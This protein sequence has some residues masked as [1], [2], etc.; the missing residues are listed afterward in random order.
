MRYNW[1][2]CLRVPARAIPLKYALTFP[3]VLTPLLATSHGGTKTFLILAALNVTACFALSV[4]DRKNRLARHLVFG[5]TLLFVAGLPDGWLQSIAHGFSREQC[6]AFGLVAYLVFWTAWLRNPKLAILGSI[7]LASTVMS[8]FHQHAG[9]GHWALQCGFVFLLLHSLRW[10]EA[11]HAGANAARMLVALG[12]GIQSFVWMHS[13]TGK[14]WM[15]LIPA[16]IV[17]GV[18]CITQ[19]Y[20]GQWNQIVVPA[21]AVLVALSGPGSATADGVQSAP[22]GL[23]AVIASFVLFGLGTAAALTR[24]YWHAHE[25]ALPASP[26]ASARA[27]PQNNREWTPMDT[28]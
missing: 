22:V 9:A 10:N 21:A 27:I 11:E 1:T 25:P 12:W 5:S 20:R 2:I 18:I 17:L 23:L 16:A 3:A 6:V 13:D 24:R 19:I 8:A 7:V 4:V 26:V 15:P 28:D 14:F